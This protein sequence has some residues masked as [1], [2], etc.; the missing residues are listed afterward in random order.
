MWFQ[1]EGSGFMTSA[2][3]TPRKR[4]PH[5]GAVGDHTWP[6]RWPARRGR[7][8]GPSRQLPGS[9]ARPPPSDK[10]L[11]L[12]RPHGPS[13]PSR[14]LQ[15]S[16]TCLAIATPPGTA[17]QTASVRITSGKTT[18]SRPKSKSSRIDPRASVEQAG[19]V[20]ITLR[21]DEPPTCQKR[22]HRAPRPLPR[23]RSCSAAGPPAAI[24]AELPDPSDNEQKGR[25]MKE[26]GTCSV[27]LSR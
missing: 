2:G 23:L 9:P 24:V 3:K 12:L 10:A 6:E 8:A 4:Q 22:P 14:S 15:E 11:L 17:N 26:G 20:A 7:R 5:S 1:Q 13:A 18:P 21:R 16:P 27:F 25:S 19:I